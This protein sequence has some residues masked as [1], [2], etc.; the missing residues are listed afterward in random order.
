[1]K[2]LLKWAGGKAKLAEQIVSYFPDDIL[3][4]GCVRSYYEPFFGGGAVFFSFF[5]MADTYAIQRLAHLS[6]VEPRL[7]NLY[8]AVA[9]SPDGVRGVL[10]DLLQA[11]ATDPQATYTE[12]RNEMNAYKLTD[13]DVVTG[14]ASQAAHMLYLNKTC[15]NGLYRTNKSGAMNTPIGDQVPDPESIRLM[16]YARALAL[17]HVK[18]MD[19]R[20]ALRS[21]E[22]GSVVYCDPPYVPLSKTANFTAYAGGF[23]MQD[24][25]D[26]AQRLRELDRY[27]VI[28]VA[29]NSDTPEV[30]E[31]YAGFE[32]VELQVRRSVGASSATRK[33]VGE[34]II[35]GRTRS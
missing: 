30:R 24:Q 19:F 35:R 16:P 8:N 22:P 33:K 17:T 31:L 23:S 27:G 21:V 13:L 3:K 10:S 14:H 34:L 11:H 26:L 29:S 7:V 4:P 25:A 20:V 2:P 12:A 18:L 9:S 5:S 32:L 15:F 6:D 28:V 1:M